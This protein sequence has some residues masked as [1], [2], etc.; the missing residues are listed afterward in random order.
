MG[1]NAVVCLLPVSI[2]TSA[3]LP[4]LPPYPSVTSYTGGTAM[5]ICTRRKAPLQLQIEAKQ[6]MQQF[7]AHKMAAI[8]AEEDA[9]NRLLIDSLS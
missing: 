1:R 3:Q 4:A 8:K 5:S 7:E 2:Y 9:A 6:R